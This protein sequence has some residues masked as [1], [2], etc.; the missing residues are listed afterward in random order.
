ME[1]KLYVEGRNRKHDMRN[2]KRR[3]RRTRKHK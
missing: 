3:N 2:R 1:S